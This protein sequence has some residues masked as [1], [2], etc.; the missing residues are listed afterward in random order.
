MAQTGF[1][2]IQ[3]YSSSITGNTP[4][5]ADL[6]NSTGGSELAINIFDGK[7]FYKDSSNAVQVIGWKVVP[8]SA[9]GTGAT[10]ASI[11]AFNNITGY[12]ATGATGTTSTN[13]VFSTSPTLATPKATTTIGVG[14]A[15]PSTSGAGITFPNTQSASTNANTLD[16]YEEGGWTPNQ[17]PALTIVGAFVSSGTYTKIGRVVTVTAYYR[18][19]TTVAVAGNGLAMSTNLPFSA[20]SFSIGTVTNDAQSVTSGC[21]TANVTV[22]STGV[23][24]ATPNVYWS[25]TYIV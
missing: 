8:V 17:G 3:L 4:A 7:L 16:D 23:I 2:P 20:A 9:G 21:L 12:T 11:T 10:S 25:V 19:G 24:A 15:T 18:P 6:L 22:L 5:A 13:L 1:T 14:D